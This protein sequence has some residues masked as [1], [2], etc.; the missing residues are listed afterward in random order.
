MAWRYDKIKLLSTFNQPKAANMDT[1][2]HRSPTVA[3]ARIIGSS[4]EP[5]IQ[6]S[7]VA[8]V[9]YIY[10]PEGAG[11]VS[12]VLINPTCLLALLTAQISPWT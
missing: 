1:R 12:Y 9:G 6:V 5:C 2:T 11:Q 8:R 7:R 4:S 10:T 3:P